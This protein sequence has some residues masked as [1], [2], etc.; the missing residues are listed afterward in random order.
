MSFDFKIS[1]VD[2]NTLVRYVVS[3]LVMPV[4]RLTHGQ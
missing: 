4:S 1:R 2:Y 3:L